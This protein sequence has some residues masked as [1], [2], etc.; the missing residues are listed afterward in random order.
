[1]SKKI[2]IVGGS[3][4]LG[5]QLA[6]LYAGEGCEVG[7]MGRRENLLT[8]LRELYPDNIFIKKGDIS[9]ETI[10]H[11]LAE[12]IHDLNELILLFWLHPLSISIMTSSP[13]R[14]EIQLISM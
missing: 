14:K 9:D 13:I 2:L 3:S 5:R 8:D 4:G 6:V 1:M 7:V 12:L 10:S 11:S